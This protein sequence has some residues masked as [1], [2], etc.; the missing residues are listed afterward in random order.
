[1]LSAQA[2]SEETRGFPVP[3]SSFSSTRRPSGLVPSASRLGCW[4]LG[5]GG[6][7]A[8]VG[9]ATVGVRGRRFGVVHVRWD[10]AARTWARGG[11]AAVQP[12]RCGRK[13]KGTDLSSRASSGPS[14]RY[15]ARLGPVLAAEGV[16]GQPVLGGG[17]LWPP[18]LESLP[19]LNFVLKKKKG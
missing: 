16:Q 6:D 13:T 5:L 12:G 19:G 9:E 3:L 8:G 7:A 17:W 14:L 1:M 2:L 10:S 15:N 18:R 11:H 4:R